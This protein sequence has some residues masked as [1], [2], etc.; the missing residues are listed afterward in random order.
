VY[1]Y[2]LI[3]YNIFVCQFEHCSEKELEFSPNL[4]FLMFTSFFHQSSS[5]LTFFVVRFLFIYLYVTERNVETY[6]FSSFPPSVRLYLYPRML[7]SGLLQLLH[8]SWN[9]TTTIT[10]IIWQL[11]TTQNYCMSKT[12]QYFVLVLLLDTRSRRYTSSGEIQKLV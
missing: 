6:P 7:R 4:W 3:S 1:Y 2:L 10:I 9:T 11:E 12:R 8:L 5:L